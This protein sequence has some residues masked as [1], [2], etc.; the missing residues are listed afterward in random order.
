MSKILSF[1]K[2]ARTLDLLQRASSMEVAH[3]DAQLSAL[4]AKLGRLKVGDS[5]HD[6]AVGIFVIAVALSHAQTALQLISDSRLKEQIEDKL[7]EVNELLA[8]CKVTNVSV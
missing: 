7:R 1:P 5:N 4:T 3:V 6:L 8:N 2:K